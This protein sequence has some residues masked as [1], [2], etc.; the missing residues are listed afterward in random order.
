MRG[1]AVGVGAELVHLC[2]EGAQGGIAT[3]SPGLEA[4]EEPANG[5]GGDISER[6]NAVDLDEGS[7]GLE[8]AFDEVGVDGADHKLLQRLPGG[9]VKSSLEGR[10]AQ[11]RLGPMAVVLVGEC[12]KRQLTE[13]QSLGIVQLGKTCGGLVR[14]VGAITKDLEECEVW[15]KLWIR[16]KSLD[17]RSL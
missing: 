13:L 16:S 4:G 2:R 8:L 14:F 5:G 15:G 11:G 1:T 9:Q 6:S 7:L 12:Q 17:L 3:I 10:V